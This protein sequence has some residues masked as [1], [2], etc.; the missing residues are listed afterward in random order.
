ME[1]LREV[2]RALPHAAT[3]P[4]ALVAYAIAVPFVVG[5]VV[6]L[7]RIRVISKL[8]TAD[9]ADAL[10]AQSN[11]APL[12]R[13]LN[14]EQWLRHQRFGAFTYVSLALLIAATVV[15]AIAI[16]RSGRSVEKLDMGPE[17][18]KYALT[19]LTTPDRADVEIDGRWIGLTPRTIMLPSGTHALR[20]SKDGYR[21]VHDVV[22]IPRQPVVSRTLELP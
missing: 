16:T 4:F 8:P 11:I 9:R 1:L 6:K 17:M 7:A 18:Q 15:V 19:V 20:I 21:V 22:E 2:L 14:P 5:A 10:L 12:G 13:A 3:T